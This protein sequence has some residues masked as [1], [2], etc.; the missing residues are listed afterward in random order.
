M[1]EPQHSLF[2][3]SG[4]PNG[5]SVLLTGSQPKPKILRIASMARGCTKHPPQGQH[6]SKA[7]IR[8]T[9]RQVPDSKSEGF[10]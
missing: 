1:S 7:R 4:I 3:T 6:I 10:A 9:M 8:V 2:Q 5:I